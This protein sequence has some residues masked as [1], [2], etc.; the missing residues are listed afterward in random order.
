M[1]TWYQKHSWKTLDCFFVSKDFISFL[2]WI[3]C[4]FIPSRLSWPVFETDAQCPT[5]HVA[6][7]LSCGKDGQ[8]LIVEVKAPW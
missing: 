8:A 2:E 4:L 3:I 6:Q 1:H 5:L 7:Q